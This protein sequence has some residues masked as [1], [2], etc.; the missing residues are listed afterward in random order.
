[1][2]CYAADYSAVM[3]PPLVNGSYK[4]ESVDLIAARAKAAEEGVTLS[5]AVKRLVMGWVDGII[6]LPSERTEKSTHVF[7]EKDDPDEEPT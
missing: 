6:Q 3:N 2:T 5:N 1:M 7:Y 4:I